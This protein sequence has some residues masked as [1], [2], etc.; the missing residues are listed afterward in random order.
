MEN[1][2]FDPDAVIEESR[3]CF[4]SRQITGQ[5]GSATAISSSH[6]TAAAIFIDISDRTVAR[7]VRINVGHISQ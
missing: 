1:E 6:A 3:I 4:L 2:Y 5:Y 7:I